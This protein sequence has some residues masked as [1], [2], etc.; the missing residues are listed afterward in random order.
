MRTE[1]FSDALNLLNDDIIEETG[2]IRNGLGQKNRRK[3][4]RQRA[5]AAVCAAC[6]AGAACWGIWVFF[7]QEMGHTADNSGFLA[8]ASGD[9]AN[10]EQ[11][12][13]L[14]SIPEESADAMGYE[15]Y[16][17]YD[18]SELVNGNPWREDMALSALPVFKN[19]LSYNEN[20]IASGADF[21]K[22]REILVETA[23]RLGLDKDSLEVTDNAPDEEKR[24]IITEKM[25]GEV[26][27][28]YFNPT[29]LK[30]QGEGLKIAVD[31]TMTA[32][33]S[34]EPE[35]ELPG[36]YRFAVHSTYDDMVKAADYLENA[37]GDFI[38]M[39]NPRKDISGGDYNIYFQQAYTVGFYDGDGDEV[40]RIFNYNFY[41][42]EFYGNE[43]GKLFLARSFQPDL[44]QK[45]GDYPIIAVE[46]AKELLLNGSYI[47]TVPYEIPG[48]DYVKKVEL[49][50]R[51]GRTEQY[52]MPYY[53]F[54]VELPEAAREKEA[55]AGELKT[56][57]AY[58]VP[59][60]ESEYIANMP[61]WDGGMN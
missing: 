25:G 27:E 50:Y 48:G 59:A 55:W 60:V 21:V 4:W 36:E 40:S 58:Y 54:Y 53:C 31:Q 24:K 20:H 19:P 2:R 39:E 33:V 37:Y 5:V 35:V 29:E 23:G 6:A 56:Y 10:R 34:F 51:T 22:M 18:I 57:G 61:L 16:M 28:G 11:G 45:V 3:G 46:K 52:F 26:P 42:T 1:Q 47:T 8:G 49:I 30:V 38:G 13:P 15:G 41:R 32:V 9:L 7:Q 14:L 17:A 43:E 12:L 44:S